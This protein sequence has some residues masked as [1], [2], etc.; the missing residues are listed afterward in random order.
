MP[1]PS[2][3]KV[4]PRCTDPRGDQRSRTGSDPSCCA[5]LATI[6][7]DMLVIIPRAYDTH[8]RLART[9]AAAIGTPTFAEFYV[10]YMFICR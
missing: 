4:C 3:D 8:K 1:R 7:R 9:G 10:V 2:T 6:S 5:V